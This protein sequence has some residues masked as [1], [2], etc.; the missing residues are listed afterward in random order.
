MRSVVRVAGRAG[1]DVVEDGAQHP[2]PDLV[3]LRAGLHDRAP[4]RGGGVG[5]VEHAVDERRQHEGVGHGEDRRAVDHDEVDDLALLGDQLLHVAGLQ[6]L[7]GV[8]GHLPAR[9]DPEVVDPA[10]AQGL[11]R[12]PVTFQHLGEAAVAGEPEEL[13][14]A[15]APEVGRDQHDLLVGLRE[16]HGQVRRGGALALAREGRDDHDRLDAPFGGGHEHAGAQRPVGLGRGTARCL[17]GHE[18]GLAAIAPPGHGRDHRHDGCPDRALEVGAAVEVIVHALAGERHDDA[19]EEPREQREGDVHRQVR[20]ARRARHLGGHEHLTGVDRGGLH[21]GE[22][23]VQE[24]ARG[25]A[26]LRARQGGEAL[27]QNGD[28]RVD[29]GSGLLGLVGE[30]GLREGVRPVG[31]EP[32]VRV[33]ERAPGARRRPWSR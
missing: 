3:E 17:E 27:L 21:L 5:H 31:R 22:L 14:H 12:A 15:R 9:H 24:G 8:V 33:A 10:A 32:R 19:D 1:V 16:R 2:R 7:R 11:P 20:R 4:R 13:V 23:L 26:S 28:L 25:R 30:V 29:R 18:V 6:Q